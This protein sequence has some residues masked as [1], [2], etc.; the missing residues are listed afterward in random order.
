MKE[1]RQCEGEG[2]GGRC[3]QGG[4]ISPLRRWHLS[5]ITRPMRRHQLWEDLGLGRSALSVVVCGEGLLQAGGV[6]TGSSEGLLCARCC[7]SN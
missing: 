1:L 7:A 2:G 3:S 6:S 4:Q 5:L